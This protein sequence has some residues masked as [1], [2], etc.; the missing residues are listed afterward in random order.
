MCIRDSELILSTN[1]YFV[2]STIS[3]NMLDL[4]RVLTVFRQ[5]DQSAI[6]V[7]CITEPETFAN[8]RTVRRCDGVGVDAININTLCDQNFQFLADCAVED[9]GISVER[10]FD[11]S[12]LWYS[13]FKSSKVSRWSIGNC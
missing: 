4:Q 10:C 13:D 9:E 3:V 5:H 12:C 2:R 11:I 1:E 8:D 6:L 7:E